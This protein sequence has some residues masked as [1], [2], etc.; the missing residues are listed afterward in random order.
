V[1]GFGLGGLVDGI[2]LHQVLQWHNLVSGQVANTTLAGLRTNLFW[3]GVFHLTTTALV[4]AGFLALWRAWQGPRHAG[5][6]LRALL[7]LVLVGWGAFHVVD[8]FVFHLLLGLHDIRDDAPNVGLY[9]WGFFA[10][11]VALAGLGTL[12]WRRAARAGS[13]PGERLRETPR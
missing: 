8:Q 4:V 1:L 11:G 12:L 13:R 10:V 9:N 7:G 2:V 6:D 5:G 3:D